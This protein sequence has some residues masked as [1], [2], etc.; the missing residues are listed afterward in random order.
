M[1]MDPSKAA[2]LRTYV[3]DELQRIACLHHG[4]SGASV[5]FALGS[6]M[7]ISVQKGGPPPTEN[8]VP[9][10]WLEQLRRGYTSSMAVRSNSGYS[11]SPAVT[12]FTT[13]ER[14][15][16]GAGNDAYCPFSTPPEF[17][18]FDASPIAGADVSSPNVLD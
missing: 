1:A 3:A 2:D 18:G 15:S 13:V 9:D 11:P 14:P 4:N 7:H 12:T 8:G 16:G 6:D 10:E 17:R 5:R